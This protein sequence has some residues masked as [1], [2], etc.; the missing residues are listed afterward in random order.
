MK[1]SLQYGRNKQLTF[2]C[3]SE[4]FES[5]GVLA[6]P[7]I[8]KLVNENNQDQ[9]AWGSERRIHIYSDLHKF[10]AALRS[11]FTPGTGN[12]LERINCNEFVDELIQDYGY[13]LNGNQNYSNIKAIISANY[14]AYI[15]DFDLGYNK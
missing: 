11:A 10:T 7:G 14:P 2:S 15:A 13:V 12:I 1:S 3:E 8:T 9:G 5:L 6:K 4:F